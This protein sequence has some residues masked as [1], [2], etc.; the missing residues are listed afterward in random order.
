MMMMSVLKTTVPQ[1][2]RVMDSKSHTDDSSVCSKDSGGGNNSTCSN[3]SQLDRE[4]N[5]KKY[6]L[7]IATYKTRMLRLNE[8]LEELEHE[9]ESIKWDVT[10][11]CETRLP[12]EKL[13]F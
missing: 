13:L 7:I 8:Q 11:I 12:E 2:G 1:V 9:L 3:L 6:Q 4:K 5:S 10:G